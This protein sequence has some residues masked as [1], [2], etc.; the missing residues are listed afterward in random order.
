MKNHRKKI[1]QLFHV[2]L[3]FLF[4]FFS[5]GNLLSMESLHVQ[6]DGGY[7]VRQSSKPQCSKRL[8]WHCFF[9]GISIATLTCGSS[10]IAEH[11]NSETG[12][13]CLP[14]ACQPPALSA[15]T[16]MWRP[17]V[18]DGLCDLTASEATALGCPQA[19]WNYLR[20]CQRENEDLCSSN[21]TGSL[22]KSTGGISIAH[23]IV[24]ILGFIPV[25]LKVL[26]KL[27]PLKLLMLMPLTL[28]LSL[29]VAVIVV[30][31]MFGH[32]VFYS[33]YHTTQ[34]KTCT[35]W[36]GD[37]CIEY[38]YTKFLNC[39]NVTT[40]SEANWFTWTLG[41]ES[42]TP[43]VIVVLVAMCLQ[44]IVIIAGFVAI[45]KARFNDFFGE[46]LTD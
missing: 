24:G 2:M 27:K 45:Q 16:E 14:P 15:V 3:L 44:L 29:A 10:I 26:G 9:L 13:C 12:S 7:T 43:S 35:R 34:A 30:G 39:A 8:L 4:L 23:G 40:V 25:L 36:L 20:L 18:L 33:P 1:F 17:R 37:L 5:S 22:A 19:E 6:D 38:R 42:V 21:P 31:S 11:Y 41:N 32:Q 28:Q 46:D